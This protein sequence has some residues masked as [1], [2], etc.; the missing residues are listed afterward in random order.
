MIVLILTTTPGSSPKSH[1]VLGTKRKEIIYSCLK[2]HVISLVLAPKPRSHVRNLINQSWPI[3][4]EFQS[5]EV[6]GWSL[7]Q[8]EV[9][10]IT[11]WSYFNWLIVRVLLICCTVL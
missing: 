2:L 7:L 9:A 5:K 4:Q 6:N 10:I 11:R 3:K 1:R 8:K